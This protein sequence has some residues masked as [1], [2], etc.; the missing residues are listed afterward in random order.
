VLDY[1]AAHEAAHL[2]EMNHSPRFWRLL[3]RLCTD[4]ARAKA[5]LDANGADL[6]R[7]GVPDERPRPPLPR[8]A[9]SGPLAVLFRL[10]KGGSAA[11]RSVTTRQQRHRNPFK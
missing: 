11:C 1:L 9:A 4:T 5:W 10:A 2:V 7:Y 6:H 8:R 3:Q